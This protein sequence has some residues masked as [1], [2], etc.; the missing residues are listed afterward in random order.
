MQNK[1]RA[2]EKKV[3]ERNSR[4]A[5]NKNNPLSKWKCGFFRFFTMFLFSPCSQYTANSRRAKYKKKL[6]YLNLAAY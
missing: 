6:F 1:E 4:T 3:R 2:R 5:N